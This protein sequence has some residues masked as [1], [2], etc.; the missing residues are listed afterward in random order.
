MNVIYLDFKLLRL[1]RPT[2]DDNLKTRMKR[3]R[4]SKPVTNL[5][6]RASEYD[7]DTLNI[8]ERHDIEQGN[9]TLS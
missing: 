9:N 1:G 7:Q 4:D 2:K 8:N 5:E 3:V 6:L